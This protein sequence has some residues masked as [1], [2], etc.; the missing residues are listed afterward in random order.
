MTVASKSAR[1]SEAPQKLNAGVNWLSLNLNPAEGY[2]F[3]L[4]DGQLKALELCQLTG[5][6]EDTVVESLDRLSEVGLV[7]WRTPAKDEA[8]I[9]QEAAP[10][11]PAAHVQETTPLVQETVPPTSGT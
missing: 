6:S 10:L 2:L 4:I 7:S 8:F 9:V 11:A 5:L 1:L 3:S